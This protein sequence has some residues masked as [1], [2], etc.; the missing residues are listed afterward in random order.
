MPTINGLDVRTTLLEVVEGK[1]PKNPDSNIQAPEI[2]RET[3]TRLKIGRDNIQ[4]R[5]VLT[6]WYEL[7][8]VGL[9]SWG[10]NCDN[11]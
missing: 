7:F 1:D 6:E 10:F 2:L 5:I 11:P 9:M 8:R 4:E 3:K